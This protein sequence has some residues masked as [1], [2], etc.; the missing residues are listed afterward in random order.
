[1]LR[2]VNNTVVGTIDAITINKNAVTTVYR[3]HSKPDITC[4]NLLQ[5]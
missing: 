5:C 4:L 1:M 2:V 3:E